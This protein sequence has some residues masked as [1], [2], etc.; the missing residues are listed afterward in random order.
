MVVAG[1]G[2]P[3][4][5]AVI[6]DA[7]AGVGDAVHVLVE[8]NEWKLQAVFATH[9]HA[10]HTWDAGVLCEHF[11]VPFRIHEADAYR[12]AD[13][14]GSLVRQGAKPDASVAV[15]IKQLL[16]E[17]GQ[18]EADYRPP[19]RVETFTAQPG[20]V[21]EAGS[22]KFE[23]IHA[24]G[25]TEGSTL[26]VT[27]DVTS[28]AD[29][30]AVARRVAFTGDV[31]FA[32]SVGRTDLPGGSYLTMEATLNR[33]KAELDPMLGIIPGHGD[34]STIAFELANNPYF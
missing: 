32:G 8:K 22:L 4:S 29:P 5:D 30:S 26:F 31:L 15:A 18:T 6:I 25:H 7:G 23:L 19:T 20:E 17:L 27:E 24:P 34:A 13:P 9:G 21:L 16:R 28:S 10:D 12:L 3:G 11:D 33:L 2:S 14:L 1:D